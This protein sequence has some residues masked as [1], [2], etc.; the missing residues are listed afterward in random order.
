MTTGTA[1]W[2]PLQ[3]FGLMG[4]SQGQAGAPTPPMFGTSQASTPP[5][6]QTPQI[7]P[8]VLGAAESDLGGGG[9]TPQTKTKTAL[10]G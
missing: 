3:L 8:T 1:S 4:G 5:T 10:G 7:N 2:N 6:K 9:I